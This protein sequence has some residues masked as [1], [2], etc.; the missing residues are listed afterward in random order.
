MGASLAPAA[1][2]SHTPVLYQQVLSALAPQA[3]SRHID[4][5]VGAG[6]HAAG[7]LEASAPD[8]ELLGLDRDPAALSRARERLGGGSGEGPLD[9]RFDAGQATTAAD[10]VNGLSEAD[11][12]DLIWRFG[13][14]TRARLVARRIVSARPLHTTTE[15]AEIVAGSTRGR[16]RGE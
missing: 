10:L 13:E 6:G 12:A 1:A 14:E 3:G 7:I 4:G 11:L 2:G 15:L 8:G 16:R 5:T 9:M